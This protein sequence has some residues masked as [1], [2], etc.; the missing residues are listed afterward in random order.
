MVCTI[1]LHYITSHH[2]PRQR[3]VEEE[4]RRRQLLPL[5]VTRAVLAEPGGK[6]TLVYIYIIYDGIHGMHGDRQTDRQG[7]RQTKR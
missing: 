1:T 4:R 5:P 6:E 2:S 3:D 7:V